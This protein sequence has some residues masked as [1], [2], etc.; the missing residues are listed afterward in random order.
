LGVSERELAAVT[1]RFGREESK[2]TA[3]GQETL[4]RPV[5]AAA[6][7]EGASIRHAARIAAALVLTVISAWIAYEAHADQ[8]EQQ[9]IHEIQH[10][11]RP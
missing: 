1:R 6:L 4:P 10:E 7:L 5:V 8:T 9:M 2:M 3:I 11:D